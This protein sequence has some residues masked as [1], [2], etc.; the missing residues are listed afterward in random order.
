MLASRYARHFVI[1]LALGLAA[2]CGGT[3]ADD[4]CKEASVDV[5]CETSPCLPLRATA[6]GAC[7]GGV[8]DFV[9]GKGGTTF[10]GAGGGV[11]VVESDGRSHA[12]QVLS[13]PQLLVWGVDEPV[14]FGLT[15][16]PMDGFAS[17]E[18]ARRSGDGRW[19]TEPIP[20]PEDTVF[21]PPGIPGMPFD[22]G[23]VKL[24][25]VASDG[26]LL[27]LAMN[28]RPSPVLMMT[29]TPTAPWT[30]VAEST[31]TPSAAAAP[32]GAPGV[33][34]QALFAD[35]RGRPR[36]VYMQCPGS[37]S[38]CD[39]LTHV[40]GD[41][42]SEQRLGV[43]PT[44]L[45]DKPLLEVVAFLPDP[46]RWFLLETVPITEPDPVSAGSPVSS[47]RTSGSWRARIVDDNGAS[48]VPFPARQYTGTDTHCTGSNS[49]SGV[50]H[51]VDNRADD[52]GLVVSST[53]AIW[54]YYVET[55][56]DQMTV[57][58]QP[59]CQTTS[60]TGTVERTLVVSRLDSGAEVVRGRWSLPEDYAYATARLRGSDL[61]ILLTKLTG[62]DVHI[63]AS[64]E[65][66]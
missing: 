53:G 61:Q 7:Y 24:A 58:P 63:R 66:D 64:I 8:G 40:F 23:T 19:T 57:T 60:R 35:A 28:A 43:T 6:I 13:H 36:L 49:C 15:D 1:A 47:P 32:P 14:I 5:P 30:A 62:G 25:A 20:F 17:L 41:P 3:T 26:T 27:A 2:A 39:V 33:D 29:K 4:P 11:V 55:V 22:P 34:Y 45:A 44:G 50:C 12:E 59:N 9:A 56:S 54:A 65:T 37:T 46:D 51:V 31:P 48:E 16:A 52:A 42:S 21:H 10:F 38:G 18:V